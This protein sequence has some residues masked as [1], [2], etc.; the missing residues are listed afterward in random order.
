MISL[1]TTNQHLHDITLHQS[2]GDA[3][4]GGEGDMGSPSVPFGG[5]ES[6]GPGGQN[7]IQITPQEKEAIERV[8]Y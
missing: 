5:Q 3:M 7:V 6:A 4:M 1:S 2:D 8:S